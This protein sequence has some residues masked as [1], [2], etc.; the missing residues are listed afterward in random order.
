M[1]DFDRLSRIDVRRDV[2]ENR[3]SSFPAVA[4]ASHRHAKCKTIRRW[5]TSSR[6]TIPPTT[7]GADS[8]Q[9]NAY[10]IETA[11]KLL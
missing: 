7:S 1:I 3:K 6:C 2:K 4:T 5:K 9:T 10:R 11:K 8:K